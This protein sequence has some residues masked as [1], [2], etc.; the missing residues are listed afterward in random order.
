MAKNTEKPTDLNEDDLLLSQVVTG[1]SEV[2]QQLAA[3]LL[4][5]LAKKDAEEEEVER[6]KRAA[7][8]AGMDAMVKGREM[9]LAKQSQCAHLKPYGEPA[10]AGQRLHSNVYLYICQYCAKEWRGNDLPLHLR[11]NSDIVGGPNF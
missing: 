10:T 2:Q 3:L 5:R 7:R 1:P 11:V 6:L 4:K 8:K 9:E